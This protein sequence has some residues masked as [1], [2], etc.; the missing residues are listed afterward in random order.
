MYSFELRA[1]EELKW[2]RADLLLCGQATVKALTLGL[3]WQNS[4]IA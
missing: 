1:R 4:A 2:R 3:L